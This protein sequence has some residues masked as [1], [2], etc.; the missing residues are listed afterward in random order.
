MNMKN[1]SY[2]QNTKRIFKNFLK[3]VTI[4]CLALASC[5]ISSVAQAGNPDSNW[6]KD[7]NVTDCSN[8]SYFG[9]SNN[10]CQNYQGDLYENWNPND[11]GDGDTDIKA[12]SVGADDEYFYFE[13]DLRNDWDFDN[14]GESRKYYLEIEADGDS[15][16]DYFLVYQPKR[17]DLGS[18]WKNKGGSGEVEVYEDRNNSIGGS[19]PNG[20]DSGDSDGYESDLSSGKN[21]SS[22]DFHVRLVNGNIQMALKKSKIGTPSNILSRA[23][24]S[25]NTNLEPNKLTWHDQ[26]TISDF[27]GSGG[28]DSTASADTSTWLEYNDT[29]VASGDYG[30]SNEVSLELVLSVDVSTSIDHQ[31]FELQRQGYIA[32]FNDPDVQQAIKDLPK[33]I[34]VT[35][36]FW[37]NNNVVDLGW[38]KLIDDGNGGISNLDSF[39]SKMQ[40]VKRTGNYTISGLSQKK[41]IQVDSSSNAVNM[42]GGTDLKLAI[43]SATDLILNNDYVGDRLVIDVSGDGIPDDTPYPQAE[44]TWE[45][46]YKD[47]QCGYTLDCPPV[48]VARDAAVAAGITI[49]GLPINNSSPGSKQ[50]TD[51]DGN[52]VTISRL[53]DQIDY[54]YRSQV[55]GGDDSFVMIANG[56]DD[57]AEAARLK[58]LKEISDNPNCNLADG[59]DFQNTPPVAKDDNDEVYVNTVTT[60]DVLSND[61][62]ANG[63]ELSITDFDIDETSGSLTLEDKARLV[64]TAPNIPGTYTF[65]YEISDG[66]GGISK[67]TVEVKVLSIVAD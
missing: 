6:S 3:T 2:T 51:A 20:A 28:F 64:Y 44:A 30:D 39:I 10:S 8:T 61:T 24:A 41:R 67:A 53:A 5:S 40:E 48:E 37:A 42:G 19:N 57:F 26:N 29:I 66:N 45:Y 23:Y 17:E 7:F 36:Q 1:P 22:G 11:S 50:V 13:L 46:G 16:S 55:V 34:A 54:Y 25:Q 31:E 52:T 18:S 56:F 12:Y 38:F 65:M 49:N 27:E 58:I 14:T 32:A 63:D 21:L 15:Q 4:S 60:L 59:C 33:G 43:E 47:G 35:M 62:D 9:S